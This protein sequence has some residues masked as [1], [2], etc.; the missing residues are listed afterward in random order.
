MTLKEEAKLIETD[1]K[2]K[3]EIVIPQSVKV[4]NT[5]FYQTQKKGKFV[6]YQTDELR[7]LITKLEDAEED[8]NANLL[9]FIRT[10]FKK[11]YEQRTLFC[12]VVSCI[13]ELD[14]LSS[15]AVVSSQKNMCK[16]KVMDADKKQ[17]LKI[18]QMWH[19]CIQ[20]FGKGTFIRNDLDM[21]RLCLL[22][23]GSNMGG[24]STLL[25]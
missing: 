21:D 19:P 22:I 11:F 23:T 6:H 5:M 1:S 2:F 24:K 3:Y 4:D 7:D 25:R 16:P 13:A 12:N 14:C 8:L 18:K 17:I 9:P 15:L 10:M 20:S